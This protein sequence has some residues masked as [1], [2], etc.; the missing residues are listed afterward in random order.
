MHGWAKTRKGDLL[1][2]V[3]RRAKSMQYTVASVVVA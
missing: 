2:L 1:E 3:M